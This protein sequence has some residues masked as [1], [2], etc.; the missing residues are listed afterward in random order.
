MRLSE[1]K[2]ARC[3][4]LLHRVQFSST[5][6]KDTRVPSTLLGKS[7]PSSPSVDFPI[8]QRDLQRPLPHSLFLL[9]WPGIPPLDG[10]APHGP[11]NCRR[12]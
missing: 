8:R 6:S 1:D 5:I 4:H 9:L 12:I 3:L 2:V 11:G 10:P 7:T